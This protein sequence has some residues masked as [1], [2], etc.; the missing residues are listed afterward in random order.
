VIVGWKVD[1]NPFRAVP[2]GP[3]GKPLPEL[4]LH[5]FRPSSTSCLPG[6]SYRW[7]LVG[8]DRVRVCRFGAMPTVS[9]PS[10]CPELW[11]P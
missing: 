2:F 9:P 8:A 3:D 5:C 4:D 11:A 6:K 10:H 7:Y 1:A